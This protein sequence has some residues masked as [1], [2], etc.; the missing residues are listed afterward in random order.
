MGEE[1]VGFNGWLD[2]WCASEE[3][4]ELWSVENESMEDLYFEGVE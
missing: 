1:D 2:V 3:L 4:G